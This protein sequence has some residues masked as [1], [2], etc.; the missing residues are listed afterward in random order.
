[1]SSLWRISLPVDK[2]RTE[3]GNKFAAYYLVS[4]DPLAKTIDQHRHLALLNELAIIEDP[5]D[6]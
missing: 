6:T 5:S 1:M 3:I 4:P 2:M